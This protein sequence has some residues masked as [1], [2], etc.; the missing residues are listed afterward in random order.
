[1]PE[2]VQ[3]ILNRIS[4]WWK[5]F[6]IK[7]KTLLVS[8]TAV[9]VLALVILGVV[10][11]RPQREL[12]LTCENATQA[13]A[14]KKLLDGENINTE[15]S[16][17]GLTFYIEHD[18]KSR[19]SILLG[20]NNIPTSG[21]GIENVF[22]GSFSTTESDK[23]KKYQL[24][25]E[26]KFEEDLATISNIQS[27]TVSLSIPKEDGTII[28][29][30]QETYASIILT[31]SGEMDDEQAAG[32]AMFVATEV[33]NDSTKNIMI[34]D[35]N[36]SVLFSGGDSNTAVGSA[37][38]Q[39]SLKNKMENK[40]KSDVR[41]VVLGTN[42]YDNVEV[43]LNLAVNFDSE[44][45]T[46]QHYYVDDGRDTG[47][48][49][50][51]S[52]FESE[53]EGGQADVPGTDTNGQDTTYVL[54]DQET[55]SSST[56][57]TKENYLTSQE[58]TRRSSDGGDINYDTSSVSVVAT[59]FVVYDERALKADGT[60]ADMSFDEFVAA[61]SDRV[62]TAVD[63]EF[64]DMVA[65]AT[66]ISRDN[67]TIVAYDVPFFKYAS[68]SGRDIADYLQI[69]LA[70]LIFILLGFVVFRSTRKQPEQ[71]IEPE[72]SAE[73]LIRSTQS[74]EEPQEEQEDIAFAEK[75]ETRILIE[76]FVENNPEAAASLLRNWLNEE[77]E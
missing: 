20:S 13:A 59:S 47:Y 55:T 33:G 28:S 53:A 39:L 15:I 61:N 52:S 57:E 72:I 12:L 23:D 3:N 76:N 26:N 64:Y 46:N 62:K 41:N 49:E 71:E 40:M 22:D 63:D 51:R 56:S 35:S 45:Y 70:V 43:G 42:L 31:L 21:Y 9:I 36:G 32:I 48:L 74:Q 11:N 77:W 44:E 30:G 19:A 69:I 6:S 73:D 18:D 66:G 25:L 29:M 7:Q 8:I 67:I 5:K 10:M 54:P 58:I 34:L 1:M 68:A 2:N 27:A 65:N 16:D 24:Y 14:V 17:D 38:T 75:S 4:E 37:N 60:L 50:S